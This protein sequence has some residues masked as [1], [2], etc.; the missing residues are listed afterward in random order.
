MRKIVIPLLF[1]LV[2]LVTSAF[3]VLPKDDDP[4][5]LVQIGQD[6][7]AF[8]FMLRGDENANITDYKGQIVLINFF[9]TWCPPCRAELPRVQGEIW[10]RYKDR[11]DF[12]LF[13]FGREEGWD[14]LDPFI[15]EHGY[16]F[17]ILPDLERKI[18]S[19]F[20]AQ[21]IPR[22]V[23]LNKEGKIVYQSIGYSEAEFD[24]LLETLEALLVE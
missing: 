21:S 4:E 17:P 11:G 14:K 15:E 20:A 16:T 22:N 13:V 10:D 5:W 23:V 1:L 9:A 18:F 3:I 24:K 7:P 6:V 19:Q 8:D 12:S 2:T